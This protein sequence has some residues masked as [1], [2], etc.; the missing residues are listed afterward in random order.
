MASEKIARIEFQL[1]LSQKKE[2]ET[3]GTDTHS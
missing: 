1:L 3:I 2:E